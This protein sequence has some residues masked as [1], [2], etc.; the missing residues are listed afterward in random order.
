MP[1]HVYI[2]ASRRYGTLYTG[3][4]STLAARVVQHRDG[5]VPGFTRQYSVTRLVHV[6]TFD[7]MRDAIVREKRIKEWKR[8]WKIELIERDNPMWDDLATALLGLPP[9]PPRPA[10][11]P[12]ES[13]D[14]DA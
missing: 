8:D 2:L 1:G 10:R 6:E 14:P 7:D 13:R 4:T 5:L 9:M 12:G 11:H 3:V